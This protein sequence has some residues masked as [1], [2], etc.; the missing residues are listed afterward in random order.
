MHV[1]MKN[2]S[3]LGSGT[4]KFSFEIGPYTYWYNY[5][6]SHGDGFGAVIATYG[7]DLD[8]LALEPL[9]TVQEY[10][11]GFTSD[12]RFTG[13]A[14]SVSVEVIHVTPRLWI[15]QAP[16][17]SNIRPLDYA[18]SPRVYIYWDYNDP[19]SN[20]Q[21]Y[22]LVKAFSFSQYSVTGFDP[23]TSPAVYSQQVKSSAPYRTIPNL[24]DGRYR[25][26]VKAADVYSNVRYGLWAFNELEV[27]NR[28]IQSV[29]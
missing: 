15:N 27:R 22:S 25:I 7:W 5:S 24:P 29:V 17:V 6:F 11:D 21:E 23:E 18:S 2:G 9:A 12:M 16:V 26:Y 8:S 14:S 19:E 10:L 1:Y 3:F 4:L 13:S 28:Y 20:Q